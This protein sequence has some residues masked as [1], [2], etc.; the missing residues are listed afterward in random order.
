MDPINVDVRLIKAVLGAELRIAPGRALMA[1]VVTADGLGR[2][3]LNI[4]GTVIDAA[5]PKDI[6]AG[7]ELRLTVRNVSAERVELSLSDQPPPAALD[8]APLPGGGTL[9]VTERDAGGGNGGGRGGSRRGDGTGRHS[10]SLR[11]DAPTI[12]SVDLRF[13]LDPETLRLSATLAAGEPYE[14]ALDNAG[15]LRDALTEALGRP[16]TVDISARR[17]PL[18]VYA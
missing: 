18:D 7:Q 10:L 6:Q 12:G 9:R 17:E 8:S 1:R 13:E 14:R 3:S 2:G 16:V 5:L 11:Y 15:G 4:A